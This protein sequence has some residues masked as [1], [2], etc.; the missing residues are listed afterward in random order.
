MS[1]SADGEEL[2]YKFLLRRWVAVCAFCVW[3]IASGFVLLRLEW[4]ARVAWTWFAT[5]SVV[6]TYLLIVLRLN[7]KSNH[8]TGEVVLLPELGWGNG[9]TILRG[10]LVASLSGFL[11]L[12]KP[13]GWLLW[14]PAILYSL[15]D[16]TDFFDG[17]VARRTN[18]VTKLGGILDLSLDGAG[19]LAVVVLAVNYGQVPTWYLAVGLAR[20][21]FLGGLWLRR[22]KT[23]PIYDMPPSVSRRVFAGL[24]MGFLAVVLWPVFSPPETFVAAAV[25]GLPFLAGFFRDWLFISGILKPGRYVANLLLA[26]LTAWMPLIFRLAAVVLTIG[27]LAFYLPGFSTFLLPMQAF[28]LLEFLVVALISSGTAGRSASILGM[29]LVGFNQF[30]GDQ[31]LGYTFLLPVYAGI[32]FMGTG[33]YSLWSPEDKLVYR[34]LGEPRAPAMERGG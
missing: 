34:R 21:L 29:L 14:L 20:Y 13:A 12:P 32:L 33:P 3:F 30:F 31:A 8:R 9:L 18:H 28:L 7:L 11:F 16:A 15:S 25:F 27:L 2:A 17:L 23:L 26:K 5:C 10:L 1:S 4:G 6:V 24:Q 22:R 19:V